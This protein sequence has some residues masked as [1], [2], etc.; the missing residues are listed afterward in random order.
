MK[1]KKDTLHDIMRGGREKELKNFFKN[2]KKYQSLILKFG[3]TQAAHC[4]EVICCFLYA[5]RIIF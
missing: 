1:Q 3:L 2:T 4:M 5:T